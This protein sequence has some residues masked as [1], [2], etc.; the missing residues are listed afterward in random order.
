MYIAPKSN[1]FINVFVEVAIEY[2]FYQHLPFGC[3][4]NKNDRSTQA[5]EGETTVYYKHT[6]EE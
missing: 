4:F 3:D 5:C 6:R 2:F 1:P